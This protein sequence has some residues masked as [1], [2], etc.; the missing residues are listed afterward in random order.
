M[1]LLQIL[2][3]ALV[4][5]LFAP[6]A[7]AIHEEVPADPLFDQIR[8]SGHICD[9]NDG[10]I[11]VVIPRRAIHLDAEVLVRPDDDGIYHFEQRVYY[12]DSTEPGVWKHMDLTDGNFPWTYLGMQGASWFSLGSNVNDPGVTRSAQPDGSILWGVDAGAFP[13]DWAFPSGDLAISAIESGVFY[14]PRTDNFFGSGASG[15]RHDYDLANAGLCQGLSTDSEGVNGDATNS[16]ANG[17]F[18][19]YSTGYFNTAKNV[20]VENGPA[21]LRDALDLVDR[22]PTAAV[23][24]GSGNIDHRDVVSTVRDVVQSA[25]SVAVDTAVP[26][27]SLTERAMR[28]A[29]L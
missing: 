21:A 4:A 2:T 11:H 5:A 7:T 9:E 15:N 18:C 13:A 19:P 25:T 1:R 10:W 28:L 14:K 23:L 3:A 16:N 24:D 8:C 20:L 12:V 17:R 6:L 22:V 26:A 29:M 27:P